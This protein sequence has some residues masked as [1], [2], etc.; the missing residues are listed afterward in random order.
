M[1]HVPIHILVCKY[2]AELVCYKLN[3][4]VYLDVQALILMVCTTIK[5][6]KLL[7]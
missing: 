3:S 1:I 7:V 6:P 2:S 4:T 5:D